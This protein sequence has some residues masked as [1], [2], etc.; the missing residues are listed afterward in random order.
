MYNS[1]LRVVSTIK[2]N[3]FVTVSMSG[4]GSTGA[5]KQITVYY[6]P[7]SGN[8]AEYEICQVVGKTGPDTYVKSA[9]VSGNTLTFE[10]QDGKKS[11]YTPTASSLIPTA[12]RVAATCSAPN[13]WSCSFPYNAGYG[14]M[15]FVGNGFGTGFKISSAIQVSGTVTVGM[16][17]AGDAGDEVGVVVY[18]IPVS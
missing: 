16:Q 8:G 9:K 7:V 11:R 10:D 3:S 2:Q 5:T 18:Y 17:G 14:E 15:L 4:S 12:V 6:V 13:T 1:D